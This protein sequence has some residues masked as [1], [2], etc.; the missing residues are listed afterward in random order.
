M[1]RASR[2]IRHD[3]RDNR[4]GWGVALLVVLVVSAVY[5]RW[6]L[7]IGW[8]PH[9]DGALAQSAERVLQ[10]QLPHRDFDEIYTG[11]LSWANAAA[12]RLFG[13]TL[14]TLRYVL[15]AA[16][17]TWVPAVFYIA[18]RFVRPVA[19]AGVVL[20][21]VAWSVPNY[22]AAMPSW[23][24]LFLATAG[25]AAIFRYLEDGRRHW[26][27]MAGIAGGLS[28]L[29]KVVGLYYVAGVLLFL[30]FQAN[31]LSRS[32]A[33]ANARRGTA[34]AVFVSA[35][36]LLFVLALATLVR[37]QL[38]L[39]ELVNFVLPGALLASWLARNEW[40]KSAGASRA[41]FTELARLIVPFL[42]GVALPIA[43][44]LVPYAQTGA[45][46]AFAT[47]VFV[48]PMRRFDRAYY[49][50]P[51]LITMLTLVPVVL[52]GVWA[53][54][55]PTGISRRH[56]AIIAFALGLVLLG[57]GT[58][59]V[60]YRAVWYCARNLLPALTVAGILWLAH[61]VDGASPLLRARATLL[62]S[63]TA[64]CGLVQFP[65]S[66]PVYFCYVA[67]LVALLAVALHSSLSRSGR[68]VSGMVAAFFTVFAV[69]RINSSRL[70]ALVFSYQRH[71]PTAQL[72]LARGGIGVPQADMVYD[73][74]VAALRAHARGGYTWAS[75][76]TPEVYF[77]SG[78]RNPTR[79]LFEFFD[80]TTHRDAR[81]LRLL[82]AHGVTAIVLSTP[83]FSPAI[84]AAM[85][86]KLVA[87]FPYEEYVGPYQLRWRE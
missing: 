56:A 30:V 48:L 87:R 40:T 21:A 74:L 45:L 1:T 64:L 2:V 80:D 36:L 33:P 44:F 53:H 23:Y 18:S 67:P 38:F 65:F 60:L 29:V 49:P 84:S 66:I 63:V 8:V 58:N 55:A 34:Y 77:L 57:T 14:R 82:D 11:G 81:V 41:R 13:T 86:A 37:R 32:A 20:L 16:F 42:A 61:D 25:V 79:S 72:T 83:S 71:R 27:F 75:P 76:D 6:H 62:V 85:Y 22:P 78:L 35:C 43:L 7:M 51:S 73:T 15:F 17:L 3:T 59:A 69:L 9:D 19:A 54:R 24:N 4:I 47:G 12:F 68:I 70:P 46:G 26:L 50:A 39:P 10:G 31:A 52:L 5:V 28:F